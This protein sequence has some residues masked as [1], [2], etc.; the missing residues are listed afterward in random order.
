MAQKEQLQNELFPKKELK[1][2]SCILRANY[3][4]QFEKSVYVF[5]PETET[6][7]ILPTECQNRGKLQDEIFTE[8]ELKEKQK[9]F[10]EIQQQKHDDANKKAHQEAQLLYFA[11]PKN[12]NE[13]L[14]NYQYEYLKNNNQEAWGKLIELSFV[15]TKR[16]IWRWLKD[17]PDTFLDDIAQE[18]KISDAVHYVLRRYKE[19]VGWYAKGNFIG[20]LKSG[21]I[22][23]MLYSTAIEENT[24]FVEDVNKCRKQQ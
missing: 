1:H 24:I 23:V 4:N 12:D 10:N 13:L 19:N 16:L 14:L 7:E 17:H 9:I 6:E 15:V 21:V 22:H 8:S 2:L 18:E 5:K 20:A 11:N 3:R